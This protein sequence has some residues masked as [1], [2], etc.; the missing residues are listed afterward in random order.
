MPRF[1]MEYDNQVANMRKVV[2]EKDVGLRT[3]LLRWIA[4]QICEAGV[5]LTW[6]TSHTDSIIKSHL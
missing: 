3:E 6:V 5:E 1:I 4:S 2:N